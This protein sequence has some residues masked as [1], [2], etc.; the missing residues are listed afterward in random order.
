[1][2]AVSSPMLATGSLSASHGTDREK[3]AGAAKQFEA[4]FLRQM[5]AAARKTSFGGEL[6]GGQ[7]L[8]TFRTMLDEH[9][10]DLAAQN[11]AFGLGTMIERQLA[12]QIS[13]SRLREGVFGGTQLQTREGLSPA[14]TQQALPQPLPQAGGEK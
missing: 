6:L 9:F 14:F 11:G 4:I 1:M 2:T 5:L 8:D 10:A 3:L 7:G 13:P 12:A